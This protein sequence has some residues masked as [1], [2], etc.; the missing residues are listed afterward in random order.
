MV[1]SYIEVYSDESD[2][3]KNTTVMFEVAQDDKA[4]ALDGAAGRVQ[5]GTADS[6]N[7][8]AL[9]GSIPVSVLPPGDYTVRAVITH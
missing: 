6:P 3:L 1:N 7:R 4:R 2:L 5:P 8:R 9:E